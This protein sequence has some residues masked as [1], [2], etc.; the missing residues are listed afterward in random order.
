MLPSRVILLLIWL[1]VRNDAPNIKDIK[2]EVALAS[3]FNHDNIERV[4]ETFEKGN[5][6]VIVKEFDEANLSSIIKNNGG[7]IVEDAAQ[8]VL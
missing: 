1:V 8:E 2:E 4:I 3:K 5:E 7:A 6:F